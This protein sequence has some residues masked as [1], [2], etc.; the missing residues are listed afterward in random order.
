[1]KAALGCPAQDIT[2]SLLATLLDQAKIY[3][4]GVHGHRLAVLLIDDG[5]IRKL[6]ARV[7]STSIPTRAPHQQ[8]KPD[9][10]GSLQALL[11]AVTEHLMANPGTL[12]PAPLA[13][14]RALVGQ[15]TKAQ[16]RSRRF[17]ELSVEQGLLP[18]LLSTAAALE[19]ARE[20]QCSS[21]GSLEQRLGQ[22][23][24]QELVNARMV[25]LRPCANLLCTNMRGCSEGR[26]RG[27][28][29]G[30]CGVVRYCSRECQRQHWVQHGQVCEALSEQKPPQSGGR[31]DSKVM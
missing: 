20:A 14:Y 12:D 17:W 29:C 6:V 15:A 25:A 3:M 26:L 23:K 9:L 1:M 7:K 21:Q 22:E 5:L 31:I 8:Q 13:S 27:R 2:V 10:A 30:G 19:A 28:R 4:Q 11:L 24:E 18:V 16:L